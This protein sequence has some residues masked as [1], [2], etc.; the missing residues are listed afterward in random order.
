[1]NLLKVFFWGL[2]VSFLGTLPL[3]T[4]N[5]A[6]MQISVQEGIA[7]AL[8]FSFG[9]ILTEMIYV[10]ISLIGIS[11][12]RKQKKLI[13]WL[14]WVT[15]VIVVALAVGSF[16]A[17]GKNSDAKN[18]M[19]NNDMNR[20]LLGLLLSA[21]NPAQIPFWLGWSTILFTKN[22]L[23]PNN[24]N[25]YLYILGIGTGSVAGNCVFVFGG[26]YLVEKLD[27]NMNIINWIIG[28]IFTLAAVIQLAKILWHKD[29]AEKIN[30]LDN[31]DSKI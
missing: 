27:T 9:C 19:L 25:Y 10:R 12:I 17:A 13:K 11:W 7:N 23:K 24:T 6:A 16:I 14:E 26:K 20:F 2:I 3:G 18:V 29:A 8:Y 31:N 28:G 21:I 22:I 15:L 5:V 1:M 4:L 30:N